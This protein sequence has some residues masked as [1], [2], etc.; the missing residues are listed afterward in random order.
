MAFKNLMKETPD[1][2]DKEL[3]EQFVQCLGLYPVGTLVKLSS[4]KLGLISQV[5]KS[6]PLQPFVRI[7]YK[8]V[9][10]LPYKNISQ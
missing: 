8:L 3:V 4:G 9:S 6:K 10:S 1:S 5:N 7:F 2:Y